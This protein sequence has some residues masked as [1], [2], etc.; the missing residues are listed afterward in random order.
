MVQDKFSTD[1]PLITVTKQLSITP[2]SIMG[3]ST[4]RRTPR[5]RT[6][7]LQ[8]GF[9]IK[10]VTCPEKRSNYRWNENKDKSEE[11]DKN[12]AHGGILFPD[13]FPCVVQ[14]HN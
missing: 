7:A 13:L 5:D 8:A 12:F 9:G 14:Q 11:R 1:V 6:L 10:L 3:H 4:W 2:L